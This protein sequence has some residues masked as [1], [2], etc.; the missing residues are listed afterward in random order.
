MAFASEQAEEDRRRE[1][2]PARWMAAAALVALGCLLPAS[3]RAQVEVEVEAARVVVDQFEG[4]KGASARVAVIRGLADMVQVVPRRRL[5]AAG[6][7]LSDQP[8]HVD[9]AIELEVDYVVRGDAEHRTRIAIYDARGQLVGE[10][11]APAPG[12]LGTS[13]RIGG[14]A[15]RLLRRHLVPDEVPLGNPYRDR[16]LPPTAVANP[17][18]EG[19]P[20]PP[21]EPDREA[22]VAEPP[23]PPS[24]GAERWHVELGGGVT[25]RQLDIA[26][27]RDARLT[28]RSGVF[29]NFHVG[30]EVALLQR[31]PRAGIGPALRLLGAV[32]LG[33]GARMLVDDEMRSAR[34]W[35]LAADVLVGAETRRALFG[36]LVGYA[37]DHFVVEPNPQV[38]SRRFEM[39]RAALLGRVSWGT[40]RLDA[41]L[42]LATIV[43]LGELAQWFGRDA[44]GWRV[45]GSVAASLAVHRR[46]RVGIA[47]SM[48]SA[49][50]RLVG[51]SQDTP[52]VSGRERGFDVGLQTAWS[53]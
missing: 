41:R 49:R 6:I 18:R 16:Q 23:P 37:S 47:A 11:F 5:R 20:A 13:A 24:G 32:D 33:V 15:R 38:P 43:Q 1:R 21:A 51:A 4:P 48:R 36:L 28:S 2:C 40:L 3:A 29:A 34:Q 53:F 9:A 39:V 52:G 14:I 22:P 31:A 12:R 27:I 42:G 10:A 30:T 17:Y 19:P 25:S 44:R 50:F 45:D 7:V 46:L 8:D 35:Q 26:L